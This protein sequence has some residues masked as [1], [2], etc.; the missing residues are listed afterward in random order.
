MKA[1]W[2]IQTPHARVEDLRDLLWLEWPD[3]LLG[4]RDTVLGL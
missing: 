4:S 3:R 2:N 1:K